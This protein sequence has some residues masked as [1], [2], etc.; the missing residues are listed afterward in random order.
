[1]VCGTVFRAGVILLCGLAACLAANAEGASEVP[2]AAMKVAVVQFQ[3]TQD[4]DSNI[5][6]HADY[7][8]LCASKGARVVV[9]PECSVTGYDKDAVS[10][11]VRARL[12]EVETRLASAAKA[13]KVYALVGM[14]T[15]SE[16]K[17]FN[18]VVVFDPAG[19][20]LE[21]YHKIHLAGE[22]WATP[23]DHMSVFPVDGV[24]CSIIV[25]HDERYPELVRLPVIAGARVVFYISHE[26]GIQSESKMVPYRAQ[27]QARAVE[28][29]VYLVHANAPA[30]KE[31]RGGSHGQS[32]I[33]RPDGNLVSEAS[34]FEEEI[35]YATLDLKQATGSLARRSLEFD[36]LRK[37]M[38]DGVAQVR[39]VAP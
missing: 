25:C 4:L 39:R 29:G 35:L 16:D 11:A 30:E 31:H 1:M 6:R 23:G 26:S 19:K 18:S 27:I 9:F 36:P 38:E 24:L 7:L 14:P 20:V 5:E 21:R 2:A 8:R 17:L 12:T 10:D 3:S 37:S 34:I 33:V 32:R 15:A 28:N 13:A 22:K